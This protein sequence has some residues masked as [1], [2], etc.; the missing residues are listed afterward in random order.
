[1]K[2][3]GLMVGSREMFASM[4][5]ALV[6]EGIRPVVD[7]VFEFEDAVQGLR[8]MEAGKHFGKIVF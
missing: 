5:E 8:R 7:Q 3:S 6:R 2:L 4:N 1:V